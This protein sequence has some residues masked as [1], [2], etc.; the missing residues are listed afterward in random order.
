MKVPFLSLKDITDKYKDEIHEAALRTID[1]GWYL[2]GKENETFEAD[3]SKYIGTK[4]TI[5][6]ANGLDALIWIFRAYIELG[7][8]KEGDEVIVPANTYIA[9]I[10]AITEN[11]LVPVLVEPNPDTLQIDDSKIEEKITDKTKAIAIVHLYGQCAYTDKIGEL[12]KK[13]NLK[14]IEDNAQAH[15]CVYKGTKTGAIGDAAGHSFYPGKNL[16]ALG[17]AGAVTTNNPGLAQAVRSL[18][19]YGSQ[20][21]YVFQYCG[22][23]S[24]LDE[25]QA[26]ILDV[27]LKHLDEDVKLRKEVA[28][29]YLSGITNP[30]IKLP[31]IFDWD[32]HVFHIFTILTED[33]EGLQKYLTEKEIG[34]NI[35]YPIPPHKQECYKEWNNLSFPVTEKI[36]QQELSLPMSPCLTDEQIQYVIDTLNEWK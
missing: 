19:N 32:Q 25:I 35:H 4:Y 9:T 10:L 29:K 33:R 17:D 34:T 13:Y 15:G 18:A 5:G 8:M 7:V 14:L 6:C 11:N 26:A 31:K 36:H 30:K 21:K 20:K 24:R 27:K 28:K 1:S 22:R 2:Q 12:C 3:Y 16:G 23:N